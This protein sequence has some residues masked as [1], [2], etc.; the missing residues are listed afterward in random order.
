L[1]VY[2]PDGSALIVDESVAE[3]LELQEGQAVPADLARYIRRL[4]AE[5]LFAEIKAKGETC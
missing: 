2:T 1:I 3:V 5:M 4:N